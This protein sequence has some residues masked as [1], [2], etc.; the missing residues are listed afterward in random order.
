MA[1]D[2][3]HQQPHG[4]QS[5]KP[6]DHHVGST[7]EELA[8]INETLVT[9]AKKY[10]ENNESNPRRENWK[11]GIEIGVAIG[12]GLYTLLTLAVFSSAAAFQLGSSWDQVKASQNQL[13]TTQ[14]TEHR[15]L[16]AYVAVTPGDVD[17]LGD[18]TKQQFHMTRKN[19]GATPAYDVG[20]SIVGS[21]VI[22]AGEVIGIPG[23][24]SVCSTPN[25]RP[26]LAGQITMFPT[27]ELTWTTTGANITNEQ[28]QA[29]AGGGFQMVYYGD[30]C[31]H[32]AFGASHYTNY[33]WMYKGHSMKSAD[34]EG[35]LQH[36]DSD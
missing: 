6:T 5:G 20:F 29:V 28:T 33:C 3:H 4:G 32:D 16:R 25:A 8:V 31:Y 26:V 17:N 7:A 24:G 12:I 34:A 19:Y 2:P 35:C 15:Q 13:A 11:F 18:P 23:A 36:N 30:V 9:F 21:Q 1:R 22:K 27:M 10:S 14:D